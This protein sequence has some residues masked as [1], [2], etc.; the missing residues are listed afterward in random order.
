MLVLDDATSALD[1]VTE[2]SILENIR[3]L[4][5]GQE[6]QEGNGITLLLITSRLSTILLADRV[7]VLTGGRIV[8]QGTHA[9]LVETSHEYRELMG[10]AHD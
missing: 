1:A 6:H 2:R 9:R 3:N 4:R 8:A 7:A 10:I 5:H